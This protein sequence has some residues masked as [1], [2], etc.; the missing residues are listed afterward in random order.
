MFN[1]ISGGFSGIGYQQRPQGPPPHGRPPGPPPNGQNGRPPGPPPNGQGGFDGQSGG[2]GQG[3]GPFAG[4]I[5][6]GI[7]NGSISSE[8]ASSIQSTQ[9]E[10]KAFKQSVMSDGQ[11]TAEEHAQLKAYGDQMKQMISQYSQG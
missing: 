9:E 1:Q 2:I 5:Q 3:G 7:Q 6:Q 4:Q 10:M 8:E 11:V